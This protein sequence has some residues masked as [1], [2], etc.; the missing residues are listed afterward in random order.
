ME[1]W[2][3]AAVG[4][5]E[6]C[7]YAPGAAGIGVWPQPGSLERKIRA[8]QCLGDNGQL[9]ALRFLYPGVPKGA[10]GSRPQGVCNMICWDVGKKD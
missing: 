8:Q 9:T 3:L 2:K 6:V 5:Q 7:R 1:S 10:G 4:E